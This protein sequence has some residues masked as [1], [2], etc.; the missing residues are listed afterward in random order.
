MPMPQK[1]KLVWVIKFISL[2]GNTA[3]VKQNGKFFGYVSTKAQATAY[4]NKPD[5]ETFS[6]LVKLASKH[7]ERIVLEALSL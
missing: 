2:K 6:N 3:Y 1:P 5:A 7:P 4:T